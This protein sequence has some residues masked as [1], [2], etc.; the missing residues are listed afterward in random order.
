MF[1]IPNVK[2]SIGETG[3]AEMEISD[4]PYDFKRLDV[5]NAPCVVTLNKVTKEDFLR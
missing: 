1:R 5:S 4:D 3:E 2:V